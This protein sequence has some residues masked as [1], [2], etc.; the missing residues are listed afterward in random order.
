MAAPL[1]LIG[2]FP[3]ELRVRS[4]F[5]SRQASAKRSPDNRPQWMSAPLIPNQ[6]RIER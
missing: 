4:G 5:G 3:A 2:T 6:I 1:R